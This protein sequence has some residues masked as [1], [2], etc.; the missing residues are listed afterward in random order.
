MLSIERLNEL[1]SKL[2]GWYID[3]TATKDLLALIDQAKQPTDEAVQRAIDWLGNK[4]WNVM[5]FA[6]R[7]TILTALRQKQTEPCEWCGEKSYRIAN[8]MNGVVEMQDGEIRV[9]DDDLIAVSID[10]CPNCGRA[11]RVK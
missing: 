1:K 4:G 7:Q 10:Y 6:T 3:I 8:T 9:Y 2:G 11:L 5:P